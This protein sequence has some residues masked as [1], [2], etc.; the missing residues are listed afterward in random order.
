M[1]VWIDPSSG[2]EIADSD[3][4]ICVMRAPKEA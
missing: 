4:A 1:T 3:T 2:I